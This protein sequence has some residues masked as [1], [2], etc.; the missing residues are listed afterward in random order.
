METLQ[1]LASSLDG[2][3]EWQKLYPFQSN[4]L[5]L[6]GVRYHFIDEGLGDPVVMVH[7]NPTWSFYYR[8]LISGLR[9]KWRAVVPDHV[10][11]G[12]SDKPQDYIYRL[13]QH[14]DN[15]EALLVGE[16]DLKNIT[17]VLHDWGG[18]IGMGFAV[19]HPERIERIVVL[20]TAGFLLTRCPRRILACRLPVVGPVAVRGFNVFARSALTMATNHPERMTEDIKAGY[21]A[22]YDNYENRIAILRF[23]Q[24]IPLNPNHPSWNTMAAIEQSLPLFREKPVLVCWGERDFCFT[25]EFRDTWMRHWPHAELHSFSDAGHYVLEDAHERILPLVKNFLGRQTDKME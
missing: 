15:L 16:L 9:K 12:L 10:G 18:A 4:Y 5:S 1:N 8:H 3:A 19:K 21:L 24:D 17:L 13:A 11:C 2:S 7:G 20:N 22:P 23:V 14:I 6:R 25:T